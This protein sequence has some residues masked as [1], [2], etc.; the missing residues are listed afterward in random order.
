MTLKMV[1]VTDIVTQRHALDRAAGM[2]A[3]PIDV[4]R[5]GARQAADAL[6]LLTG[7]GADIVFL[8]SDLEP[9]LRNDLA[10]AARAAKE[11][12]FVVLMGV[13][14]LSGQDSA[15][16]T[17]PD[18]NLP[19]QNLTG[20]NLTGPDIVLA[21]FDADVVLEKPVDILQA[22]AA[23]ERCVRARLPN[24][25]L[26]VDDSPTVRAIVRKI[27]RASRFLLETEEAGQGASALD[28]LGSGRF[29][30]VFLDCLMP[31]LDG[32]ATMNEIRCNHPRVDTVMM[33]AVRDPSV[34][35]R[36]RAAGAKS[37]LFKPF[38]RNDIDAVLHTLFGLNPRKAASA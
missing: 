7:G 5:F 35:E 23:V 26:V 28:L 4:V 18:Q 6:A 14:T 2:S 13:P 3:V 33:T 27:M 32:F 37:F 21:D 9:A 19:D 38:F 17:F 20:Q 34:A 12:A 1:V 30:I 10:R 22:C 15:G 36:A 16:Q 24:R 8:D 31:G 25:V 11:R 29:D